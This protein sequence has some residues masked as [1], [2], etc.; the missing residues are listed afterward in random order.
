MSN[1]DYGLFILAV[2]VVAIFAA[3]IWFGFRE[4]IMQDLPAAIVNAPP[5]GAGGNAP[6]T[7]A[8]EAFHYYPSQYQNQATEPSAHIEAY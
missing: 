7:G 5:T 8:G 3:G 2:G 6:P 1:R 4:P